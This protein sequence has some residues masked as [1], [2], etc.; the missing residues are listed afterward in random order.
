MAGSYPASFSSEPSGRSV[1]VVMM[2]AI[3]DN[4]HFPSRAMRVAATFAGGSTLTQDLRRSSYR[5]NFAVCARM[6]VSA[7]GP[8]ARRRATRVSIPPAEGTASV[9]G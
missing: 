5:W 2:P 8:S 3:G 7:S 6:S 4:R 9:I 1:G